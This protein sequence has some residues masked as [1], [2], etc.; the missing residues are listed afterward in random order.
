MEG[1]HVTPL[2]AAA[3]LGVLSSPVAEIRHARGAT[4]RGYAVALDPGPNGWTYRVQGGSSS[5]SA[6]V[7]GRDQAEARALAYVAHLATWYGDDPLSPWTPV[8]VFLR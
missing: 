2:E 1:P 6:T 3:V 5:C 7:H 4:G 8:R